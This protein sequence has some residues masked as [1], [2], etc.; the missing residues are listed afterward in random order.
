MKIKKHILVLTLTIILCLSISQTAVNSLND[1]TQEDAS[2]LSNDDQKIKQFPGGTVIDF[3]DLPSGTYVGSNYPGVVFSPGYRTWNST[4]NSAFLPESGDFVVYSNEVDNWITFDMPI[5]K[6]GLFVS[7]ANSYVI[8]VTAYTEQGVAIEEKT[9]EINTLNQYVEFNSLLGRI[10]NIT[11]RGAPGFNGWWTMDTLSYL[12]F[13]S[14]TPNLIDFEDLTSG[15]AV[16][17]NYAGLSFTP[18][19]TIWDSSLDPNYPPHS[20]DNVIYTHEVM[21]NITFSLPI[22]SVS[23]YININLA[24]DMQILA[25]S[26]SGILLEKDY[27]YGNTV[28]QYVTLRSPLGMI[29]NIT[30]IGDPGFHMYWSLDDLCYTEYTPNENQLLT[31]DEL[32]DNTYVE[33]LYAGVTFTP[34]YNVWDSL[35]SSFYPPHSGA[36]VIYSPELVSNITFDIPEAYVSFYMNTVGDYDIQILAYDVDDVLIQ[37]FDVEPDVKNQLV[38]LYSVGGFINRISVVGTTG[39]QSYWTIDT[40]Y[41]EEYKETFEFLL[42]FEDYPD[43]FL[44]VYP[45]ITF[46]AGYESWNSLGNIYYPP[47]SGQNVAYSHETNPNM[48]FTIPIMYTSFYICSPS[49][50]SLDV[51]AYTTENELIFKV[52]VEPDSIDKLV[53][54]YS[55][56]SEISRITFNGTTGYEDHW[57]IDNLYYR[58]DV[59][60]YD[61]DADG[62]SYY[63]EMV[64][65]TDPCDWDSDDD[66]WSDGDEIAY[67][68]DPN[69]PLD[70][71]VIAPEYGYLAFI[72]FVPFI[73]VL[74]LLFRRRK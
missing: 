27:T 69:N 30:F 70:Y 14:P 58:A 61:L 2:L 33:D 36:N 57:T 20:G 23:F 73:A 12:E 17:E 5:E 4:G 52:S 22:E 3:D 31:F 6:V 37:S 44:N 32:A 35:L 21:P 39:F 56:G 65:N 63:D 34:A 41:F 8:E 71:P 43:Y 49:D 60:T 48:T 50:Y 10:Q 25:Y 40:L 53:E 74:G 47:N 11:I 59:M 15:T 67:G 46:S 18:D 28:H 29:H 7:T 26:E 45:H 64:Y 13:I 38:E 1:T 9:L 66:G 62:L 19:F 51:L 16:D 24:Y 55:E 54:I 42:D 72:L 68:T